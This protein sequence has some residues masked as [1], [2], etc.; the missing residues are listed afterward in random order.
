[1]YLSIRRRG[2]KEGKYESIQV[3]DQM[4]YSSPISLQKRKGREGEGRRGI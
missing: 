3:G 4:I 2:G 1:M